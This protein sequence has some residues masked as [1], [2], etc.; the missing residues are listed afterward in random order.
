MRN[1]ELSFDLGYEPNQYEFYKIK[2]FVGVFVSNLEANGIMI[3]SVDIGVES[4]RHY[5]VLKSEQSGHQNYS[6][7]EDDDDHFFE[8]DCEE[9]I[10]ATTCWE[11][12]DDL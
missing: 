8:E 11:E 2:K 6:S 4:Q 12:D 9:L 1:I 10:D 7:F 5:A 3:D